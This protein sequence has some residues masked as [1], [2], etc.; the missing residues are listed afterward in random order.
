MTEQEQKAIEQ[1]ERV[2][3][4]LGVIGEIEDYTETAIRALEENQKY[5]A[6][7]TPEEIRRKLAELEKYQK[8]EKPVTEKKNLEESI[9]ILRT[10][11]GTGEIT[12]EEK[13]AI[14]TVSDVLETYLSIGT[15][16]E[17]Q[18]AV[19]KQTALEVEKSRT[20]GIE[21]VPYDICPGCGI[22]LCT[23]GI[24]AKKKEP[25]CGNCGQKLQWD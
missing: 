12:E 5:H 20:N 9:E 22:N 13:K 11:A 1:L 8:G 24:L 7:G 10:L 17:C 21:G 6:L 16:G 2:S 4:M 19:L 23:T 15:P 14:E 25:Y 18:I 3:G